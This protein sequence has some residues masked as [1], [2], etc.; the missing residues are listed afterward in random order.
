MR[1]LAH[2]KGRAYQQS[3]RNWLADRP[4]LG[5]HAELFGDSYD[6][7]RGAATIGKIVFDFS[8]R[9]THGNDTKK[10]LYVECKLR[11]DVGRTTLAREFTKFIVDVYKGLLDADAQKRREAQFCFISNVPPDGWRRFLADPDRY[12]KE[13]LSNEFEQY[14]PG[15]LEQAARSVHVLVLG[16]RVIEGA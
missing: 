1:E 6:A 7:S 16:E 4:F 8:L 9:L 11:G 3:V 13:Q 14:N 5:L 10:V 15:I 12:F 2:A